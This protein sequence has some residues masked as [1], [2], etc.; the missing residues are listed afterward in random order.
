MAR[1]VAGE[2][3]GM[4]RRKTRGG[5][6][7][8]GG[9]SSRATRGKGKGPPYLEVE[10]KVEEEVEQSAADVTI[11]ETPGAHAMKEGRERRAGGAT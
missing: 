7:S 5:R 6:G 8:T 2:V 3:D 1:R 10:E 4:A 11:V 9:P